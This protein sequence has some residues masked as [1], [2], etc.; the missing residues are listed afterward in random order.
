MWCAVR[1][2]RSFADR[3]AR[4]VAVA[5]HVAA[6]PEG[7]SRVNRAVRPRRAEK[8]RAKLQTARVWRTWPLARARA[9]A[10]A[11]DVA[12]RLR[13][14]PPSPKR[15][16]ATSAGE[17][18]SAF[19]HSDGRARPNPPLTPSG[20]L[21][22]GARRA[23]G[24]GGGRA[25]VAG[26]SPTLG[27]DRSAGQRVRVRQVGGERHDLIAH[28]DEVKAQTAP[29]APG[30]SFAGGFL[31]P[32]R[33]GL[34]AEPKRRRNQH[35]EP[36]R[37]LSPTGD[38]RSRRR[39]VTRPRRIRRGTACHSSRS[40]HERR[41][42][43]ASR[44]RRSRAACRVRRAEAR[45]PSSSRWRRRVAR[46]AAPS[47]AVAA[48]ASAENGVATRARAAAPGRHRALVARAAMVAELLEDVRCRMLERDSAL[49]PG[50]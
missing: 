35:G 28:P 6:E 12:A 21:A 19:H 37:E 50:E 11:G 38:R 29:F 31:A 13:A 43:V 15:A 17:R 14:A 25:A 8:S 33:S 45:A 32:R 41:P 1:P 47:A 10:A 3:P 36:R 22:D 5:E 16:H 18:A 2:A 49:R 30:T 20:N 44:A 39:H 27:A 40:H 46:V 24:R 48:A 34:P 42:R 9:S 23:R 4:R 26:G 7:G